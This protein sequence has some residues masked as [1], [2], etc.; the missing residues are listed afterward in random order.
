[1][2]NIK[3]LSIILATVLVLSSVFCV[4]AF[5]NDGT[6]SANIIDNDKLYAVVP[7][8]YEY[9]GWGYSFYYVNENDEYLDFFVGE[10]TDAPK[11]VNALDE[12]KAKEIVTKYYITK[13]V[14]D[15]ALIVDVKRSSLTKINGLSAYMVTGIYYYTD[16]LEFAD[17]YSESYFPFCSYIF[18]TQEDI[19]IITYE[20]MSEQKNVNL[21][22][23]D[24]NEALKTLTINGTYLNGD[25]PTIEHSFEGA[26][27]YEADLA[28]TDESYYSDYSDVGD[29]S[30]LGEMGDGIFTVTAVVLIVFSVGPVAIFL[31]VAIVNIVKYSKNKSKLS[32][33]QRTYGPIEFYGNNV[34]F[35]P[36]PNSYNLYGQNQN[37]SPYWANQNQQPNSV[38]DS[39][40]NQPA[41]PQAPTD[42]QK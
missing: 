3:K 12:E 27:S 15:E 41:E 32:M 31:I 20:E 4:M 24:L 8:D 42:A 6:V 18:A 40:A 2:K 37:Q 5:A 29:L 1:M 9:S 10:N 36:Q 39:Q 35:N 23:E 34:G 16:M 33:Y 26:I 7:D 30:D 25:K 14:D 38:A 28:A 21:D 11:G 22:L 19:F 13:E 17:E